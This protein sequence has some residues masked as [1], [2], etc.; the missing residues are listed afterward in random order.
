MMSDWSAA[1]DGAAAEKGGLDLE[2]PSG[3][4]M[5]ADTL[6]P[7]IQS[8]KIFGSIIDQKVRRILRTAMQFGFFGHDRT[9]LNIPL[10]NQQADA[11]TL[12][13]AEAGAALLKNDGD[14]LPL[15]RQNIHS[16]AILWAGCPP[17]GAGRIAP[18]HGDS[19][20]NDPQQESFTVRESPQIS[21]K[22]I[23][24]GACRQ[25][26]DGYIR[27]VGHRFIL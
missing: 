25:V 27:D 19:S 7:A 10:F 13:A 17:G 20:A 5:N 26:S 21:E 2:M 6:L 16:I 3:K 9:K 22:S 4:F 8:G 1:H 12:E 11:V 23:V 15:S 24:A 14:I 18:R